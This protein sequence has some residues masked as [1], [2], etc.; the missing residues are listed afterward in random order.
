MAGPKMATGSNYS[1]GVRLNRVFD[2]PSRSFI[3]KVKLLTIAKSLLLPPEEV[4]TWFDL[5]LLCM[6]TGVGVF[7]SRRD[8]ETEKRS[9]TSTKTVSDLWNQH[10][11]DTNTEKVSSTSTITI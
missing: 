6:Q 9:S 2:N 5:C 10:K 11:G 7:K 1:I 4:K 3:M 8:K